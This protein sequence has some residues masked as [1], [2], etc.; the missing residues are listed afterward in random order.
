M[1]AVLLLIFITTISQ[2]FK[3]FG[4]LKSEVL[5]ERVFIILEHFYYVSSSFTVPFHLV[6]DIP[7]F[8]CCERV[9]FLV[10]Y[11]QI[12]EKVRKSSD[13]NDNEESAQ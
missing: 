2:V 11:V 6:N 8:A 13:C 5:V 3:D 4:I 9:S 7:C 10:E 1:H 12:D